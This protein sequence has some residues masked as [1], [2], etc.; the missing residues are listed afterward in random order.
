MSR[1]ATRANPHIGSSFDDFLAEEG[2][3]AP[4]V[5]R[6]CR[7]VIAH[8]VA[9]W[10]GQLGVSKSEM[11]RRMETSRQAVDRLLDPNGPGLTID[12]LERAALA[13]GKR[14]VIDFEDA[15]GVQTKTAHRREYAHA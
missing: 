11:A 6:A 10:M 5:D 4:V 12:T 15:E 2:I 9:R 13:V 14:V 8:L 1:N 3:E 7:K